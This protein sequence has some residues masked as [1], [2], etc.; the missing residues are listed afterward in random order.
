MALFRSRGSRNMRTFPSFLGTA[1]ME[2]IHGVSSCTGAR[3]FVARSSR[4]SLRTSHSGTG[5]RCGGYCT[6]G[7]RSSST[8]RY[9]PSTSPTPG[10]QTS[11]CLFR[12][13]SVDTGPESSSLYTGASPVAGRFSLS[14][15]RYLHTQACFL[16][17]Q[18]ADS[19]K[20]Y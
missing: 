8:M 5:T 12:S 6:G 1:T 15:S 2:L 3:I 10:P 19:R 14:L 20:V 16:S 9:L 4:V 7:S 17:Q 18:G 13:S 11:E